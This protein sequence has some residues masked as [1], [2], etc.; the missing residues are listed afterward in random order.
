VINTAEVFKASRRY[1]EERGFENSKF[2][3]AAHECKTLQSKRVD[4]QQRL[5]A[6]RPLQGMVIADLFKLLT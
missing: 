2:C 6:I 1:H 3:T 4:D 5:L